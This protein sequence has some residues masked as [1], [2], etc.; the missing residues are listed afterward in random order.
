M[1][2]SRQ[3]PQ[4][5]YEWRRQ[6]FLAGKLCLEFTNTVGDHSKTRAVEWLP[7]WDALDAEDAPELRKMGKRDPT[8]AARSVQSLL[9]FRD[10]LTRQRAKLVGP[11][12]SLALQRRIRGLL[13]FF[14][15]FLSDRRF[16]SP[17]PACPTLR[18]EAGFGPWYRKCV[19][20]DALVDQTAIIP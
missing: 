2:R 8:A 15:H 20:H 5:S 9:K 4:T 19:S 1:K 10:L 16:R 13:P 18:L 11:P 14:R 17:A 6:D 12:I 3:M 7:G